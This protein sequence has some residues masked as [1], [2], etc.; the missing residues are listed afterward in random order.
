MKVIKKTPEYTIYQKR[1]GRHAVKD[2]DR[3]WINGEDK[4]KILLEANLIKL[5]APAPAVEEPASEE[6]AEAGGQAA[7][8]DAPA[9]KASAGSEQSAE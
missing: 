9:E 2:A 8:G 5:A 4:V 1:S 6:A 7:G 3:Q